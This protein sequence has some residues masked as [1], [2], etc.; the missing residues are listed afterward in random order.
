M[1][2]FYIDTTPSTLEASQIPCYNNKYVF[3]ITYNNNS[4]NKY[5]SNIINNSFNIANSNNKY[6]RFSEHLYSFQWAV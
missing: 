4:N 3:N 5:V 1:L 2:Y 6:A